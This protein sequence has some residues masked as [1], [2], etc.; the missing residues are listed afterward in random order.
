MKEVNFEKAALFEHRFWLQILGDHARMILDNLSPNEIKEVQTANN[1][2]YIFDK[3]LAEA[4]KPLKDTE[5]MTL[6]NQAYRYAHEIRLFKLDLIRQHLVGDIVLGLTPTFLNHMVNEVEEYLRV[7]SFLLI[8][9]VPTSTAIH[10][11]LVWLLDA[12]GHAAGISSELDM[13]EKKLDKKSQYFVETFEGFYIKAVELAGYMRT[14]LEKFPAM[15]RFNLQVESEILLFKD[16][17]RELEDLELCN[18]VLGSLTPLMLDHMAR[19]E[20]YYLI[21]L[22]ESSNVK[23][24]DCDPTK[25]RVED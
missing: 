11:H 12:A 13:V 2:I 20:C 6:T 10:D 24:P 3:L 23:M 1:F 8:E 4:R 25:P 15:D 14:C 17:L 16:F 22:A 19:E 9:Q 21:K 18:K 7:L 5:L